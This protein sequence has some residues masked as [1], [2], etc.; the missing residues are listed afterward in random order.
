LKELAIRHVDVFTS[1]AFAGNPLL[2]VLHADQL[3]DDEMQSIAREFEMPETTFV[4]ASAQ[5]GVDYRV[6][7]FTPITEIP[8]AGHPVIGTAH[9]VVTEGV[10]KTKRPRSTLMHETNV[11]P[12]PLDVIQD[13]AAAPRITMTL[14]KP[15]ILS[16]LNESQKSS[17]ADALKIKPQTISSAASPRIISTGLAQLFVRMDRLEDVKAIT[18]DLEKLKQLE[19]ALRITGVAVFTL[20]TVSDEASAHLRFFAPSIGITEDAAAGS[21]AGG[22]GAYLAMTKALPE[23]K[24]LDFSIEQGLELGRP[25]RLYV[26]VQ[27]RNGYPESVK[28]GGYSTTLLSGTLKLE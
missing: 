28:V 26:S 13:E 24:L 1:R 20:K 5:P 4:L 8:F 10:V 2:V 15:N 17:L 11:G 21:A 22:L 25:S 9:V 27:T 19:E 6:R 16:S 3:S 23:P 14:T 12:I 7:I 18:P